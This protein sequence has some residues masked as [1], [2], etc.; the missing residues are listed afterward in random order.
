MSIETTKLSKEGQVTIPAVLREKYHWKDG[1]ELIIINMTDG[2]LLKPKKVFSE[3]TL[4]EVAGC[5]TYEKKAK[6]IEEMNQA[7]SQG[8]KELWT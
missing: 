5:L 8:I 1:E 3:T 2:I 6:S 7:I 4:D